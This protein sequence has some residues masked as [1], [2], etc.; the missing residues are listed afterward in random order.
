MRQ[1]ETKSTQTAK[2]RPTIG[3]LVSSLEKAYQAPIW[4]GIASVAQEA[5]ANLVC[6]VGGILHGSAAIQFEDQRNAIYS[7][8]SADNVDGLIAVSTS[9]GTFANGPELARFYARYHPL[10]MVSAGLAVEGIPSVLV[11]N[12]SGLRDAIA[13]LIRDHGF[14]RIAFICGPEGQ[15]EAEQ[16]YRTYRETLAEHDI[17]FDP[18]LVAPGDFTTSSAALALLFD[19]RKVDLDAIVSANDTMAYDALRRL[20]TR[21]IHVPKQVAMIGFDD[22][23]LVESSS[24]AL[25]TVR[26][27]LSQIG[28][29]A[30]ELLF[31]ML[32]GE[33]VPDQVTLPTELIV[34]QSCGC[35]TREV[36]D[37]A[38][39]DAVQ[40][41]TPLDE[42]PPA[43]R[44][45]T[46]SE[47]RRAGQ[48]RLGRCML[49]PE[50]AEH[51][52]DALLA[53]LS[54]PSWAEGSSRTDG[55]LA[56][57]D[58][59][60]RQVAASHGDMA[61]WQQVLSVLRRRTLPA[62]EDDGQ[63]LLRAENLWQQARVMIGET[64]QRTLSYQMVWK[65]QL[66]E[67]LRNV[68]QALISAFDVAE[69][70]D[71]MAEQLPLL[72]IKGCYLALYEQPPTA[73]E[74]VAE[75]SKLMLAYNAD[76]RAQVETGGRRFRSRDLVPDGLL[77]QDRPYSLIAH[78]LHFREEQL[79]F[80][81]FEA[82][83]QEGP[84]Y[85]ALRGQIGSALKGALL[86]QE[87]R[88][89]ERA[90]RD[91]YD[92]VEKQVQE[93]TAELQHEMAERLRAE[94]ENK[95][96]QEQL[97][98]TQKM[99]AIGRL[100]GGI[101]HDFNNLLT[102]IQGYAEFLLLAPNLD[103]PLRQDVNEI[104]RAAE[105]SA[106][107]TRQLLAFSRRQVIQPV[108]LDLN[109]LIADMQRMLDRLIGEDINLVTMLDPALGQIRAD[110]GQIE[111]VIL[112]LSLNAR[113]AMPDGGILTI[114][115][116]NAVIDRAYAR[117]HPGAA[118][119]DYVRL[120]VTDNGIGMDKETLSHLFE[121][122]FTTKDRD[123]GTGLGL[124]TV[125]GIVQQNG[126]SIWPYSELGQG[127]V[128]KIYL[129]R[130]DKPVLHAGR[131]AAA[132]ADTLQGSETILVLE[133]DDEVR[134]LAQRILEKR[135]Y[136]VL[137][138]DNADRA[139]ALGMQHPGTIHLLL[140]DV[141]LPGQKSGKDVAQALTAARRALKVIFMSGYT[142]NVIAHHGVLD[143]DVNFIPKPF[144]ID[145]LA[146]TVREVLDEE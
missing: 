105:R 136:V 126:G 125:Y 67:T 95:R 18:D 30:A 32:D 137:A 140:T 124:A 82:G 31:A 110:P 85:R 61:P 15:V 70:C 81:L 42:S 21:G 132:A 5:E 118:P 10:P 13:H 28:R 77:P 26:Q 1:Q 121:P 66:D 38:V 120:T 123:K 48:E 60:L 47:M 100:A 71:V 107:L 130:V 41:D 115:T 108:I 4:R 16:R 65:K 56:A 57:L 117:F 91:A 52:L 74:L 83:E 73:D 22:A 44:E 138:A 54:D 34:R 135:G 122:F 111:Q 39:Y 51:L 127:T 37:A 43:W 53:S 69:L 36:A 103:A 143:A 63:V 101:A 62:L 106:A 129:P 98:Q 84:L 8:A 3:L 9:I 131:Q 89:A 6:F 102:A 46:L 19:E 145:T 114:E 141:I 128:F 88:D 92:Q 116:A 64:T 55:F 104:I 75:W 87:R 2:R 112:N 80:V 49:S 76:G 12:R 94:Q 24:L 25:T 119:G 20:E 7:L 96:L 29:Q 45:R 58:D 146:R 142:D 68:G 27:P 78:T 35:V 59:I 90:L 40:T 50:W 144:T 134:R 97:W 133:D 99:E 86:L 33:P 113:D 72:G 139:I 11:D 23:P 93:R 79:G 17:P 109:R 14:R